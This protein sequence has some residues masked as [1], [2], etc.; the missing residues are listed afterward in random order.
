MAQSNVDT[1]IPF[2]GDGVDNSP[3]ALAMPMRVNTDI[4]VRYITDADGTEV[5][6][7]LT[8]D[9]TIAIASDKQSATLT[10]VTTAPATGETLLITLNAAM[11]HIP[12]YENK[13]NLAGETLDDDL[14]RQTQQNLTLQEQLDRALTVFHG[15]PDSDLPIP[16]L[17]LIDNAL[18]HLRV[19]AD[20]SGWELVVATD[21]IGSGTITPAMLENGTAEN[22]VLQTQSTPFA[23]ERRT[24]PI[25]NALFIHDV[26]SHIVIKETDAA[27]D[28]KLM[29]IQQGT[30]QAKFQFFKDDLT[31]GT[32]L[33]VTRSDQVAQLMV[34]T[35]A[36]S[37]HLNSPIIKAGS[38]PETLTNSAG[39]VL[40]AALVN[41]VGSNVLIG[42]VGSVWAEA[43]ITSIGV[44]PTTDLTVPVPDS[45]VDNDLTIVAG[46]VDNSPIGAVTPSTGAFTTL[47]ASGLI[48][49]QGGLNLTLAGSHITIIESD[50]ADDNKIFVMQQGGE[51]LLMQFLLDDLTAIDFFKVTRTA[52]VA[53]VMTL[54]VDT[55]V[56]IPVGTLTVTSGTV[57][58]GVAAGTPDLL[59]QTASSGGSALTTA[60]HLVLEGSTTS[61]MT[62]LGGTSS[63]LSIL[64]GDSGSSNQGRIVYS[65][66]GDVMQLVAGAAEFLRSTSTVTTFNI[67]GAD[68]DFRIE[69]DT[70][71]NAFFMDGGTG[72]VTMQSLAGSGS[73]TVVADANGVLSAP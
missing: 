30:T 55:G 15:H 43:T 68:I 58:I 42:E 59:I 34:L 23:F 20:E 14:D 54:T 13:P 52:N 57:G 16:S 26:G 29:G 66:N 10:L 49:G 6:K 47:N 8:T 36:V 69:S 50:A 35:A 33:S 39:E 38:G 51:E 3:Y 27:A 9:Y 18:K 73:R 17:N 72:V 40:L 71:A 41:P 45:Q 11:I 12:L 53:N 22:Q 32:W 60:D 44:D 70:L 28:N 62:L 61:G 48:S 4:A 31:E 56:V 7:T 24:N 25:F 46:T 64:F 19:L 1:R 65:N 5:L 21:S 37:I 63:D 2:V 67:F